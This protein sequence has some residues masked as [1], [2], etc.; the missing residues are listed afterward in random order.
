MF[1]IT[2]AVIA[3]AFA[4]NVWAVEKADKPGPQIGHT[5]FFKLKASSPENREKL[6]LPADISDI[7]IQNG[8]AVVSYKDQ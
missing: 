2:A 5:V 6:K 8:Q 1:R 4:V 3:V 7:Q